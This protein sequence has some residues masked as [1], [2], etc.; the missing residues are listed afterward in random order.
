MSKIYQ[1]QANVSINIDTGI[2]LGGASQTKILYK[3]PNGIQGSWN[4]TV[5]GTTMNYIP[6]NDDLDQSGDWQLQAFAV[7]GGKNA[8]GEVIDMIVNKPLNI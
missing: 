8:L 4:A 5:S 6:T 7:I 2:A 1:G 3:K